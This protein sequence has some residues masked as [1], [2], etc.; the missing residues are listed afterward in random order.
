MQ[1]IQFVLLSNVTNIKHSTYSMISTVVGDNTGTILSGYTYIL[2]YIRFFVQI[3]KKKQD[4]LIIT[5]C[6]KL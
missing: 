5:N 6:F 2:N 1:I 4:I 3:L